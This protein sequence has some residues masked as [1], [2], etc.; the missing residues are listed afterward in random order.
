MESRILDLL[1]VVGDDGVIAL[2]RPA[3]PC[4]PGRAGRPLDPVILLDRL[5]DFPWGDDARSTTAGVTTVRGR[6]GDFADR[7]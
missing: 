7:R 1:E 6:L 2:R 4:C 5:I 3:A